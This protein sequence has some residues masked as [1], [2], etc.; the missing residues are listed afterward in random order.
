MQMHAKLNQ[1]G[2]V[3]SLFQ[4]QKKKKR[5]KPEYLWINPR[6]VCNVW[7]FTRITN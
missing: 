5:K 7:L 1:D 4:Q 3:G 6:R 2:S